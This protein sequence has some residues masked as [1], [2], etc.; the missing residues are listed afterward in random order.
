MI[1]IDGD[2][3]QDMSDLARIELV[4]K[5]GVAYESKAVYAAIGVH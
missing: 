2:P 1:L 3:L 5:D 4:I